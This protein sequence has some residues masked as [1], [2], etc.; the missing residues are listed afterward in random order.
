VE[1]FA[2]RSS[3]TQSQ[4]AHADRSLFYIRACAAR[5]GRHA[6]TSVSGRGFMHLAVT[7]PRY[8]QLRKNRLA[9]KP[10]HAALDLGDG[11]ALAVGRRLITTP[12]ISSRKLAAAS[13]SPTIATACKARGQIVD[14]GEMGWRSA[15]TLIA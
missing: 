10:R 13:P 1:I 15:V 8:F 11:L 9:G 4:L 2:R 3:A 7:R 12:T 5:L 6:A 14:R